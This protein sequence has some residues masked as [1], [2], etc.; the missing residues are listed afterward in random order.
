MVLLFLLK[1][2][3]N[4]LKLKQNLE[5]PQH[6]S[7]KMLFLLDISAAQRGC[8]KEVKQRQ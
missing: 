6:F 2:Y 1:T 5:N 4:S 8:L 3:S 7:S